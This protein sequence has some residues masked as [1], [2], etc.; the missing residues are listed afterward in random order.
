MLL[1]ALI[2]AVLAVSGL[3]STVRAQ[4]PDIDYD[5]DDDGLIEVATEAQLNAIRWDLGGD[6]A[7]DDSAS[8]ASYA[9][10]FADAM[11]GM[12]CPGTCTGYEL[13]ADIT[14]TSDTGMGWEPIG[15]TTDPFTANFDGNAPDYRVDRLFINRTTDNIGLFGVTGN[16]SSIR[17]VK[18]TRVNVTGNDVVGAL[19]GRNAGAIDNC[20]VTGTVT[21]NSL[22]G[23]LVGRNYGP[24][25]GSSASVAVTATRT[26]GS[27]LAGG[28]VGQNLDAA[29]IR[30]SHAS[31]NVTASQN[32]VGGLVGS[33][34][35]AMAWTTAA[36]PRN[37]I[38]GST[39]SGTVTTTG[40]NVGGLVGWNNGTISDSAALNPSVSGAAYVGGLVGSNH[41]VQ[42]DGSNTISGSTARGTVTITVNNAGG[43]VGWS[44]GP[45]SDSYA[46][47]AVRGGVQMGGLV[48]LNA[49]AGQVIDS[50]ADGAV[51][52]STVAGR[53]IGGLVGLN[54]GSVAGSVAT[55]TVSG[56]GAS[57]T[58]GGLV[59]GNHGPISGSAATG[60]VSGGQ[61]VGGL[62]GYGAGTGSVT[63]SWA[64][65]A[66]RAIALAGETEGGTN[67]GGLV[68]WNSGLVGASFATGSVTGA[69]RAGGL[70]G[71]NAGRVIATYATGNV[72]GSGD[73]HCPLTHV[74]PKVVGGLIGI[75]NKR[76]VHVSPSSVEASYSTGAVRGS[77][78]HILGGLV[79]AAE[80]ATNPADSATFTDS[81]WD[82][83]TSRQALGV[84]SDDV[85]DSGL[86]V[87]PETATDGVTGQTTS[88]LKAPTDYAGIFQAWD[89]AVPST[90]GSN[91]WNFGGT[92][93]YPV[94]RGLGAPPAFPAGTARLPVM[95][96]RAADAPIGSPLV[97]TGG[98]GEALTYKLVGAAAVFF[99]IDGMTGQLLAK[100]ILDYESPV[101]ANRDNTYE[102]MVQASDGRTV[103]FRNVAV[104]VS[105]VI[106]NLLPPMITGSDT[107]TVA[108]NSTAVATYQAVDP[109]GATTTFT[110]SLTGTD[111]AAFSIS[112]SG[113]LTFDPVPDFEV[114]TDTGTDSMD[115][116]YEVTVQADDGGMTDELAV[117]VTVEAVDEPPDI[118]GPDSATLAENSTHTYTYTA[119]DPEGTAVAWEMLGG[120][121]AQFFMFVNGNLSFVE[122]PDFEARASN[123]Y[124]VLVRAADAGA[125]VGE[126]L[127][128]VTIT[129]VDEAPTIEGP[130]AIDVN[131]GHT[132]ALGMYGK[133]DPEGSLSNWGEAGGAE[134]L[135]GRDAAFFRFDKETG[136]LTFA[137]DVAPPDFEHGD[138]QYQVTLHANDG[139]L[140]SSLTVTVNV[141]NVDE[142][143]TLTF[144]RRLPVVGRLMTAS[145][146]DPDRLQ[147]SET[148]WVWQRSQSR[149]GPWVAIDDSDARRDRYIPGA[150]DVSNYLRATVTYV[151]GHGSGE[152]TLEAIT[153]FATVEDRA[154]DTNVAPELPDTAVEIDLPE[155]ALPGANVGAPV[156]ATDA[157][158]D[159]IAYSF[160][161]DTN[162]LFV[163]D[164]DSGQ[165]TVAPNEPGFD[166]EELQ[167]S[168]VQT[169]TAR[170]SF[171]GEDTVI[172]TVTITDV[173]EP[174]EAEDD[175]VQ[176]DED[177]SVEIDILDNDRDIDRDNVRSTLML[178]VVR[179]PARGAVVVNTP[180]SV[181][182]R[183]F[184]YTPQ[185]NYN[186]ADSFTYHVTDAGG[187]SSNVAT[188]TLTV[189]PVNDAPEFPAA[190]ATRSISE[191]AQTGDLVGLPVT[192]TDIDGDVLTYKKQSNS[193]DRFDVTRETGQI[194]R[195]AHRDLKAG[196]E[197]TVNVEAK[198]SDGS[199]ASIVVTIEITT[200]PVVPVVVIP[201]SGGGGGLPPVIP[202][203]GGGGGGGVAIGGGGF[204]GGGGGGG[205]GPTPSDVDF[206]WT[207]KH[208][209][210]GLDSGHDTPSGL[211]SDGA[212]L[213]I[214]ENGD[215]ADDAIYA[216]DLE[217]GERVEERE[218]ALDEANR[219]PRGVWSDRTII[220]VA[221]SGRNRLFAHNLE[222][223]ERL[224]ERDLELA[225]RNR[226]ARGIWSDEETMWVL[227]G[228]KDALFAYDLATGDP[229]AEYALDSTNGDPHGLFFDGV[230]FWVSDHGAKRLF[231]YRLEA[232]EDGEAELGRNR[233]EEFPNT[234]LSRASNN[235]PRGIWSDGDVM[236]VADESD[237][238][239]YT[240]NMPD[241]VDARLASL[242]LSGV[243]LGEFSPNHEEYE[244][245]ADEGVSET[246][247]T[248]EAMQRLA[249]VDIDP[250]DADEEADGHQVALEGLREIIVTV[251]SA[252]GT[253][254]RV[255]RV[256]FE[257]AAP[258]GLA[259]DCLRG[260]VAVGFS[261]LI[262]EG[263][264]VGDLVGCA[265]SRHVTALYALEGGAYVSYIL[266]APEF[267]NRSFLEL[268][269]EG[270][271]ATTL[272]IAKSDGPATADPARDDVA[273]QS[274]P[275]CLRG[276]IAAG[277]SLVLYEGGSVEDLGSC[278]RDR[279]VTALY[280]IEGGVYAAYILGAP[281]FVNAGFR[282]VFTGGLP[283]A[284]PLIAKSEG[285]SSTN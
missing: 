131:E 261:I 219:A 62:V 104:T 111:A 81:Y 69:G 148:M 175:F 248:A 186:G 24:I 203:N 251:T 73:P 28:L 88:A 247:V 97:A 100:T 227:D 169:V 151:D 23:G 206:E 232:G 170:D 212:T 159:P 158:D 191:E 122:P 87:A 52:N 142:P 174:P 49:A 127:V 126:L 58:L 65:G 267:V 34:Y 281:A 80:R 140:D 239:V 211:W 77:S 89:V 197:H 130:E 107:V 66:V 90:R 42:A 180:D 103:A 274:W 25:S 102:F 85:D 217:S 243:D 215:G 106:E 18:L 190:T 183:T 123:V 141:A 176:F 262:Y 167:P 223:G 199:T 216:Y 135:S 38:S 258:A 273:V 1:A 201:P 168:Y 228:G 98:H 92:T 213:W 5:S 59:G 275:E 149:S 171:G 13:A 133:V 124:Q 32:T 250:P 209:I 117:F 99:G 225:E 270:V 266:G 145:L 195:R 138:P 283:A 101:D 255:Y 249:D 108:E 163:I 268:Y 231:A 45:I 8:D 68:G 109:D 229:T 242:S 156:L 257:E 233:D 254:T 20:E 54:Q 119:T 120:P 241:A 37:A 84:A 79:G 19:V 6:G 260:A 125:I 184:T 204:V 276:E 74:C 146:S 48:G 226:D 56:S 221:D 269:A 46:S 240:Y 27:A 15:D 277:F 245:S 234:I 21:G 113:E 189:D 177:T 2:C 187:L 188:V 280:T 139:A 43:L 60:A 61:Q 143:G 272:V 47:G 71:R 279:H 93:D 31:G 63:E 82:T 112:D 263:G 94:L 246:T 224:P 76:I 235:S 115:N 150:D 136:L 256:G 237:D 11:H 67:V 192:A 282:E 253:R 16:Q 83:D 185:A 153:E 12:G 193:S 41:D 4:S 196:D 110:W 205:G 222:S 129:D 114:P 230:T 36:P 166:F 9:A 194:T 165:I 181:D 26:D 33:N 218:F 147:S 44:N 30:N 70:I 116:I 134:A 160:T 207:V 284:S 132:R 64:R 105:D 50:R 202:P 210:E 86:I 35:D 7:V 164:R 179:G 238:K 271:P 162:K 244:G 161:D 40:S 22:L 220:W 78:T 172:V 208:D 214:A 259:P 51:G 128:T 10:A 173:P 39:A 154:L 118:M 53:V 29:V 200:G 155:N 57:F 278:A 72:T 3:D 285:P 95:E 121:D 265:E 178:S 14:L 198:D 96:E 182:E 137:P 264:S 17:N 75:A 252:D 236:Y 157:D 91:H 55:G 152:E 144:D